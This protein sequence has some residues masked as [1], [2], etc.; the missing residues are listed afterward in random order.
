MAGF[1]AE[2]YA[3]A[4][5][6]LDSLGADRVKVLPATQSMLAG[7]VGAAVREPEADW[8]AP[9]PADWIQGGA[10][11]SQRCILFSGLPVSA[12]VRPRTELGSGQ[13]VFDF[14]FFEWTDAAGT[15][16]GRPGSTLVSASR[17]QGSAD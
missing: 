6:L 3:M 17:L 12:Q 5:A 4:R 7:P 10:W 2:E 15:P 9:R 16:R 14:C 8:S 13:F 11:G 1:R